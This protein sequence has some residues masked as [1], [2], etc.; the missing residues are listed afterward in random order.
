MQRHSAA[1]EHRKDL[2]LRRLYG[3][4]IDIWF[5]MLKAQGGTCAICHRKGR[6][7]FVDH[8]HKTGR[9]RGLLCY[10]CNRR[11]LGRGLEN[12]W[13]HEQAAHYLRQTLDWRKA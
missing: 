5:M 10:V 1:W 8:D 2:A 3:I 4:T 13:L 6:K 7:L 9:V 12:P 11:L